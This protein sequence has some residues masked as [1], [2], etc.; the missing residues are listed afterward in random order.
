MKT[1]WGSRLL[2]DLP[3]EQ[4]KAKPR[5]NSSTLAPCP[6][7]VSHP[8]PRIPKPSLFT[9]MSPAIPVHFH[10]SMIHSISQSVLLASPGRD[11]GKNESAMN[12]GAYSSVV[13]W[14]SAAFTE[15]ETQ[16]CRRASS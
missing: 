3:E 7:W 12:Q 15:R 16:N 10:H 4:D 1:Y 6:H 2:L 9:V 14:E 5:G 8:C 11:N 13:K